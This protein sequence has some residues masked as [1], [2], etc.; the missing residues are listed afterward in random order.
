MTGRA[1]V[2]YLANV[3]PIASSLGHSAATSTP[4][5]SRARQ[6]P[7]ERRVKTPTSPHAT[8]RLVKAY[9]RDAAITIKIA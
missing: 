6:P 4:S 3:G 2:V 9:V 1:F 7:R 8:S 5:T